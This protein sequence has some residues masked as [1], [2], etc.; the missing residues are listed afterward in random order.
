MFKN[1]LSAYIDNE[2][3]NEENVKI[4][5]FTINNS[6]ARQDLEENY[7]IKKMMNNSF[8]KTK[9]ETKHDFTRSIL[10][11]LELEEE[12][13][14]GIHPLIKM[15]IL[16]TLTVLVLSTLTIIYLNM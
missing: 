11:Q 13:N 9:N 8:N 1:N 16:F 7:T 5:K 10:R 2:L 14:L 6:K 4:K 15:I 12:V 3:S